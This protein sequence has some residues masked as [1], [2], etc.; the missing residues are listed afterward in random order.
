MATTSQ[1]VT[2]TTS[3]ADTKVKAVAPV[4]TETKDKVVDKNRVYVGNLS[5]RTTSE[6]LKAYFLTVCPGVTHAEVISYPNGRS[7]GCGLVEFKSA[8]EAE[9]AIKELNNTELGTR[10]IF[11]RED[12][13]PKGFQGGAGKGDKSPEKKTST[14]ST[15]T[16]TTTTSSSSTSSAPRRN[17]DYQPSGRGGRGGRGGYNNRYNNNNNNNND[18]NNDNRSYQPRGQKQSA[19]RAKNSDASNLYV[20]NLPYSCQDGDLQELFEAHGDVVKAEVAMDRNSRSKGFGT[21]KMG[22]ADDAN[23]AITELNESTFQG[24]KIVVRIDNFAA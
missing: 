13:E 1:T 21:V 20:G 17:N 4:V 7:K 15:T 22:S 6:E 5:Y 12:R 10:K 18:N 24:R 3:Q 2:T 14:T 8:S 23:N 9:K 19:P 11:I 16:A